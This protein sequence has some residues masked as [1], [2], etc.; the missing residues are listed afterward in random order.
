M[1]K[2]RDGLKAAGASR[3]QYRNEVYPNRKVP[4]KV[5][6]YVNV[7]EYVHVPAGAK[8]IKMM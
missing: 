6:E 4:Y 3:E 1:K 8:T 7:P 5:T 2:F